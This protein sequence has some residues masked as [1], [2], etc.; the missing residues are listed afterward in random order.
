M[1]ANDDSQSEDTTPNIPDILYRD[2]IMSMD[3]NLDYFQYNNIFE[4][5]NSK[6]SMIKDE[7]KQRFVIYIETLIKKVLKSIN[8]ESINYLPPI[9][10]SLGEDSSILLE[11]VFKD[12]RVGFAVESAVKDSSWYVITGAKF[13]NFSI[14]GELNP[15]NTEQVLREKVLPFVLRNV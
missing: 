15:E 14:S 7:A 8:S 10:V 2:K 9:K 12:Y 3:N 13:D 11:W 6:I 5:L 1:I 4:I